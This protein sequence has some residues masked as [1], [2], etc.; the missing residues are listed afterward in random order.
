MLPFWRIEF[1]G[2]RQRF[3]KFVHT[4]IKQK[5]VKAYFIFRLNILPL[6]I[7][8]VSVSLSLSVFILIFSYFIIS[9]LV[10]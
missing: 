4:S 3:G 1:S 9:S 8:V 5:K 6:T 10:S 2:S 7:H